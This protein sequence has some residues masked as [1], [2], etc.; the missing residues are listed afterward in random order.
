MGGKKGILALERPHIVVRSNS[1][2]FCL[3]VLLVFVNHT[4]YRA[5]FS[6]RK[7]SSWRCPVRIFPCLDYEMLLRDSLVPFMGRVGCCNADQS[8]GTD[9]CFIKF[10]VMGRVMSCKNNQ[11]VMYKEAYCLLYWCYWMMLAAVLVLHSLRTWHYVRCCCY[12][13]VAIDAKQR[14][15][16]VVSGKGGCTRRLLPVCLCVL[17]IYQGF[18]QLRSQRNLFGVLKKTTKFQVRM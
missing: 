12:S 14:L 7:L 8:V 13:P 16:W 5:W 17:F 10:A 2:S 3:N 9:C 11:C 15:W 4:T 6:W 1:S 18:K